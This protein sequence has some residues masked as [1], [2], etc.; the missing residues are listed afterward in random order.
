MATSQVDFSYWARLEVWSLKETIDIL[1]NFIMSESIN[2]EEEYHSSKAKTRFDLWCRL[3]SNIRIFSTELNNIDYQ[4]I[5][6]PRTPIDVPF[7]KTK[8]ANELTTHVDV[9][10]FLRW[11]SSENLKLPRELKAALTCSLEAK[12]VDGPNSITQPNNEV[13]SEEY[14]FEKV[15]GVWS[16]A[17]KDVVLKG[18]KSVLGLDIIKVLLQNP[19][20]KFSVIHLQQLTGTHEVGSNEEGGYHGVEQDGW[21]DQ[22]YLNYSP[23]SNNLQIDMSSHSWAHSDD[24]AIK[25]YKGRIAEIDTLLEAAR[26]GSAVNRSKIQRL[27]K[28]REE[29]EAHLA[30]A[31]R[32]PKDPELEKHRKKITKNINEAIAKIGNLESM[33]G[34]NDKPISKHLNRH[35]RKGV[36]CSYEIDESV[37]PAWTF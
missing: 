32:R 12:T 5:A 14:Q 6:G 18:V 30:E 2:G 11:A 28:E 37:L 20:T 13:S 29:I 3:S 22:S 36:C 17:Y 19:N 9:K 34:Y 27:E 15:N 24:T 21:P 33:H 16:I 23:D 35:I 8:L 26:A 25:N 31:N 7:I 4:H 10:K 1:S